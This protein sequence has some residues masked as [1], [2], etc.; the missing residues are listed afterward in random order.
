M[1]F[2]FKG[3]NSMKN[4]E[5]FATINST[6]DISTDV[7]DVNGN[8]I[9]NGMNMSQE[10]SIMLEPY[11][12]S[13]IPFPMYNSVGNGTP[14][15]RLI[16]SKK[17]CKNDLINLFRKF[18]KEFITLTNENTQKYMYFY[19]G[20]DNQLVIAVDDRYQFTDKVKNIKVSG[21]TFTNNQFIINKDKVKH[22]KLYRDIV[23]SQYMNRNFSC[24][25]QSVSEPTRLAPK[26]MTTQPAVKPMTTQTQPA[27]KP[28]PTQ[29]IQPVAQPMP[30][31]SSIQMTERQLVGDGTPPPNQNYYIQV[32][33]T[34]EDVLPSFVIKN[35]GL[36]KKD[37][38]MM[39]ERKRK[40]LQEKNLT[41]KLSQLNR[42]QKNFNQR[43]T[44]L[45][46]TAERVNKQ[47]EVYNNHI[48]MIV[49][50]S[51]QLEKL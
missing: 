23:K 25:L 10:D 28:M 8:I 29:P 39:I 47:T 6:Q 11:L 21:I 32:Q 30:T 35:M 48:K 26:P 16:E 13:T 49:K 50:L 4:I 9:I 5:G 51:N 27:V 44:M 18:D 31:Q 3:F 40:S 19:Y 24:P 34:G 14:R 41:N 37:V 33:G 46:R 38:N 36:I 20:T 2:A 1:P 7:F 12:L 43:L 42:I 22:Y 17:E 45:N 15:T